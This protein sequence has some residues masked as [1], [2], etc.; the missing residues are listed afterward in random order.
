MVRQWV[1]SASSPGAGG[2]WTTISF[3]SSDTCRALR[4][5]IELLRIDRAT[6][7]AGRRGIDRDGMDAVDDRVVIVRRIRIG[8]S[9]TM[10]S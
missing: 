7:E 5:P 8:R 10:P 6:D 9:T 1:A 3:G 2:W 4:E